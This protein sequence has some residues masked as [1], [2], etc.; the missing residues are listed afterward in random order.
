MACFEFVGMAR[1]PFYYCRLSAQPGLK[2]VIE[3][4]HTAIMVQAA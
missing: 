1:T 2:P 3:V 4:N